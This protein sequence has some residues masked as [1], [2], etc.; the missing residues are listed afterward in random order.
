MECASWP[1]GR[2]SGSERVTGGMLGRTSYARISRPLLS[3]CSTVRVMFCD[4][5]AFMSWRV[6]QGAQASN[7][8]EDMSDS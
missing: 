2:L 7:K 8:R 1:I 3:G 4:T 6:S 5:R